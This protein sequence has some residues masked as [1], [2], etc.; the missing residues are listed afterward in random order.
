MMYV[1]MLPGGLTHRLTDALVVLFGICRLL[2]GLT[3]HAAGRA[4]VTS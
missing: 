2:G 4:F 3:T 1:V